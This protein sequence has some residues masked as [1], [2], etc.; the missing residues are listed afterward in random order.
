MKFSLAINLERM[1]PTDDMRAVA[2][3]MLEMVQLAD[4]AGFETAWAAE[5]HAIE[6]TIA[7]GPF[8][9][10]AWWAAHTSRI[11]LGTAV[12]VAAYWH[13]IRLAGE[14]ALLEIGRA[15]V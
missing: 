2:D 7:P 5:H 12:A 3:H 6:M 4:A 11:R 1:D 15:H 10:L 13:P 9:L 8:Q 14:C